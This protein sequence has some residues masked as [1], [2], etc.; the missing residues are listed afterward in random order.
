MIV[1]KYIIELIFVKFGVCDEIV[2]VL[3]EE[4]IKWFFVI[5]EFIL[6]FV[7]DGEDVIGQVCIGMGK[8]FVFGVLL[9]QCIIF[10]DGMRLF[11]GVLWVLVVVFICELCLQVIDDLVMVGKYLIVGFDIDDVVVVW[12]WLLVVF[13]YGGWF[14]ELQ[15]EVLCVGVDVVVGILGWLFDLCQQGY[16]QLGGLFVLVF[17]EVDEMFDL[18]FLF[19]IE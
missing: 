3:G 9:L 18:G 7:F 17:D 2:C 13:I 6:L 19:D 4:G 8:M 10:G 1:V 15:I 14:Y 11:I 5:Q 12:C 16:L